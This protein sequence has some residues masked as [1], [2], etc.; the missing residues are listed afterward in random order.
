ND[1]PSTTSTNAT[2]TSPLEGSGRPTTPAA[3]TDSCFVIT[4]SISRVKTFYPPI[5]SISFIR[6]VI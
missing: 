6:P 5:I 4:S 1:A 2:A 3:E